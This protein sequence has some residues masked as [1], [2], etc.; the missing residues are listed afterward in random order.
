MVLDSAAP[1]TPVSEFM[2]NELRFKALSKM[3]PEQAAALA[4]RAQESVSARFAGYQHLA[5]ASAPKPTEAPAAPAPTPKP[6]A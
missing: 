2:G 5:A 3:N 4:Q 1:K 6:G